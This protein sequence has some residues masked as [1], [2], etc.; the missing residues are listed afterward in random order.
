MPQIPK[1]LLPILLTESW[2][3]TLSMSKI[4]K[5][6]PML[7]LSGKKDELVPP[8]HMVE[9]RRM[10]EDTRGEM[11]E[12]AGGKVRWREFDHG[13]HNDTCLIGDYWVEIGKWIKEEIE[14]QEG[15]KEG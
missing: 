4:P 15:D 11:G 8:S 12:K 10:R 9:L 14:D 3:A 1:F 7:M 6:T 13:G 2:D 5:N